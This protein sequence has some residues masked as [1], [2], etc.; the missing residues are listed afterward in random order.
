ML[1]AQQAGNTRRLVSFPTV[2]HRSRRLD[3]STASEEKLYQVDMALV[4]CK[5][6]RR[7][8]ILRK[9]GGGSKEVREEHASRD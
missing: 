4:R 1:S 9:N 6:E 8:T 2:S 7:T 3:V 5:V